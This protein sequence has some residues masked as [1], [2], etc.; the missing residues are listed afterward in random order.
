MTNINLR[1]PAQ[2][3]RFSGSIGDILMGA[4]LALAGVLSMALFVA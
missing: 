1:A 3:P 4:M 2:S